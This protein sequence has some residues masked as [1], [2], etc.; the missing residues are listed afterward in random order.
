MKTKVVFEFDNIDALRAFD[1][2]IYV[3]KKFHKKQWNVPTIMKLENGR[4]AI[5]YCVSINSALKL[6]KKRKAYKNSK[7]LLYKSIKIESLV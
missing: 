1:R 2:D 5:E 6:T 4:Y 7:E 3:E